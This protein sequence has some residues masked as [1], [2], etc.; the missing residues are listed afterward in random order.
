MRKWA[1]GLVAIAAL[2]CAAP[3]LADEPASVYSDFAG[4]GVLNCG[5]SRS[6]LNGV[7]NDA[8]L[9]QYGDPLTMLQLKF[10]IRKQL[11]GGCRGVAHSSVFLGPAGGS[12]EPPPAS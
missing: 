12:A 8:S 4:D 1:S 7:L 10:V 5:H 3:A 9:Y 2:C 6:A 11:E